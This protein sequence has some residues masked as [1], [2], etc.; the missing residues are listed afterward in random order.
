MNPKC[1]TS[2]QS[3]EERIDPASVMSDFFWQYSLT[4]TNDRLLEWYIDAVQNAEVN[5]GDLILFVE[6]LKQ[7]L[8]A[9]H[10]YCKERGLL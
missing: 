1:V 6:S 9:A 8:N 10:L 7:V 4:E 2:I 5:A 3:G